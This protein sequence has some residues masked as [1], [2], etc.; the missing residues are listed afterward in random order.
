MR[1]SLI[2]R[3]LATFNL[4]LWMFW[5]MNGNMAMIIWKIIGNRLMFRYCFEAKERERAGERERDRQAE[6]WIVCFVNLNRHHQTNQ[7]K[8]RNLIQ[9][10]CVVNRYCCCAYFESVP[11]TDPAQSVC[12][13]ACIWMCILVHRPAENAFRITYDL[14]I[15]CHQRV[16]VKSNEKC[17][18][19]VNIFFGPV[20]YVSYAHICVCRW[21]YRQWICCKYA[22]MNRQLQTF[23]Y[24][25]NFEFWG[26]SNDTYILV[27]THINREFSFCSFFIR[28]YFALWNVVGWAWNRLW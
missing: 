22:Y 21:L 14:L 24:A 16:S 9:I 4:Y 15:I 20:A 17:N 2:Q 27:H 23:K 3:Q 25:N 6:R 7:S 11:W 26:A 8:E 18:A 5:E 19:H 10:C 28:W 1:E 12:M 13:N